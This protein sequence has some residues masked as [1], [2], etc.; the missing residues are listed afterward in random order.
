MST[1]RTIALIFIFGPLAAMLVE[2]F[3]EAV[4]DHIGWDTEDFA[5]PIMGFVSEYANFLFGCM[6]LCLGVWVHY[7]AQRFA[8]NSAPV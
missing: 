1:I 7:F 5:V 2:P 3:F 4:F 6:G 8:S